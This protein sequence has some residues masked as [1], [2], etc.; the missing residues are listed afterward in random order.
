[1]VALERVLVCQHCPA[2]EIAMLSFRCFDNGF[3]MLSPEAE[4]KLETVPWQ[5]EDHNREPCL[6]LSLKQQHSFERV[7][8]TALQDLIIYMVS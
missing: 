4:A 8:K 5:V 6:G 3:P 7:G 2:A 1:M